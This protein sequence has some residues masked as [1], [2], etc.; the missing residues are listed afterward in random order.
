MKVNAQ[1]SA[2]ELAAL[3]D[4]L[5]KELIS[6]QHYNST[7]EKQIEYMRSADYDPNK[8]LPKELMGTGVP[9]AVA[10]VKTETRSRSLSVTSPRSSP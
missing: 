1:K 4:T 5:K 7:L 9:K 3:I 8:P 6:L 2:A 10:A